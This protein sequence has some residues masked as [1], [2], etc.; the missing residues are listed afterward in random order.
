MNEE[1]LF[2][3]NDTLNTL[4][5]GL[6]IKHLKT[7]FD[8]DDLE[9]GI[10][11]IDESIK[12]KYTGDTFTDNILFQAGE[13]MLYA[14]KYDKLNPWR[15]IL[16]SDNH[17]ISVKKVITSGASQTIYIRPDGPNDYGNVVT[18]RTCLT[19]DNTSHYV[20]T[21]SYNPATKK[22]VDDA[23]QSAIGSALGGSY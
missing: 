22:Y 1:G 16:Y 11:F 14:K 5:Q 10:Y 19:K 6:K 2:F 15:I 4:V 9:N 3:T 12:G 7:D 23:I 17:G 20:P 18:N 8:F 21:D 13:F